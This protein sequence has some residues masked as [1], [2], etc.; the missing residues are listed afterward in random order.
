[1]G[2]WL[3]LSLIIVKHRNEIR[4][5]W[6]PH[7]RRQSV[8]VDESP[9]KA[10]EVLLNKTRVSLVHFICEKDNKLVVCWS[11]Q[12][13]TLKGKVMHNIEIGLESLFERLV[14]KE[15]LGNCRIQVLFE[16]RQVIWD[17]LRNK[18]YEFSKLIEIE[19]SNVEGI[20][21]H[22]TQNGFDHLDLQV[23]LIS[24][25]FDNFNHLL[26]SHSVESPHQLLGAISC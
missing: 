18:G 2:Q 7:L 11:I 12:V 16:D 6:A 4:N 19:T 21:F 3:L 23:L 17:T 26:R 5:D 13:I 10:D 20:F 24:E 15:I 22:L 8:L 25:R 1:M 9:S 14:V